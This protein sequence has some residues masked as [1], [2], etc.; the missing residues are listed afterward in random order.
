[1][2]DRG[3]VGKSQRNRT[4]G[5]FIIQIGN[6]NLCLS[7]WSHA[8]KSLKSG[9]GSHVGKDEDKVEVKGLDEVKMHDMDD[10]QLHGEEEVGKEEVEVEDMDKQQ[11][12]GVEEVE[13]ED[14]D[15]QQ[16][17]IE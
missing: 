6:I 4:S 8:H 5:D 13:V 1:M 11:V 3:L 10:I 12:Q 14:M 16:V 9:E 7:E 15:K 2:F 17:E